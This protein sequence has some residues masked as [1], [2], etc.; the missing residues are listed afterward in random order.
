M[1]LLRA[2]YTRHAPWLAL[3]LR[4]R[5]RDLDLDLV[6]EL[7]QETFLTVWRA[8]GTYRGERGILVDRRERLRPRYRRLREHLAAQV[9]PRREA[10]SLFVVYGRFGVLLPTGSSVNMCGEGLRAVELGSPAAYR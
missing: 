6:T 1:G 3:R 7:L 2:F 8:A 4:R 10:Y 9:N 5:C